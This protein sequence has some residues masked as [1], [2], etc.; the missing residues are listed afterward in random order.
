MRSSSLAYV[1]TYFMS[2]TGS[3]SS[4]VSSCVRLKVMAL[5]STFHLACVHQ[6]QYQQVRPSVSTQI[7]NFLKAPS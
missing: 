6:L 3:S 5:L 1:S 2:L 7:H 4:A